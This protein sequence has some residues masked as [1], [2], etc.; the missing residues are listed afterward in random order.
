MEW[1]EDL[2]LGV[3]FVDEDHKEAV[4]LAAAAAG[5]DDGAL[6][7]V[8]RRIVEHLHEHFAREEDMMDEC[9]FFAAHCHKDEHRR[10]LSE[11]DAVLAAME[12]GD[13]AGAREWA[14]EGFPLW[15]RSHRDTMDLVTTRFYRQFTGEE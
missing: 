4:A 5:A 8:V 3:A 11:A 14:T 10:V 2:A 9:G 15:F 6:P 12:S 1:S 13:L 7:G